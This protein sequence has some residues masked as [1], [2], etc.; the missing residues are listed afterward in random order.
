LGDEPLSVEIPDNRIETIL[1]MWAAFRVAEVG[2]QDLAARWQG[3]CHNYENG[4]AN[5]W[6][7]TILE[8]EPNRGTINQIYTLAGDV[9]LAVTLVQ[10][11]QAAFGFDS[12]RYLNSAPTAPNEIVDDLVEDIRLL[13]K[14]L[15]QRFTELKGF[16]SSMSQL[17]SDYRPTRL[18]VLADG[19][20][21]LTEGRWD[22]IFPPPRTE[23]T[24]PPSL[25]DSSTQAET[26]EQ[27]PKTVE[28]ALAILRQAVGDR[29]VGKFLVD[30]LARLLSERR[31]DQ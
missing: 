7:G 2:L 29:E 12:F 31:D 30:Q 5:E 16:D 22:L 26:T 6:M 27:S 24:L 28:D 8:G 10:G 11:A 15:E 17:L 9:G 19:P 23:T 18:N 4:N 25:Q 13:G 3:H 1:R 20:T 14:K 21:S